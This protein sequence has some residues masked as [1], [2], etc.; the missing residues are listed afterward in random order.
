[1]VSYHYLSDI[2]HDSFFLLIFYEDFQQKT[3]LLLR[4]GLVTLKLSIILITISF[5][6]YQYD[7]WTCPWINLYL[8]SLI[9]LYIHLLFCQIRTKFFNIAICYK[10][11]GLRSFN[12]YPQSFCSGIL[13]PNNSH[14]SN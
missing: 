9:I 11:T 14:K 8:R 6:S 3:S 4:A 13:L 12:M 5:S 2:F 7:C 10:S 1:M